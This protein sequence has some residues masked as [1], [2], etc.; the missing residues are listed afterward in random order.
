M[1]YLWYNS[2]RLGETLTAELYFTYTTPKLDEIEAKDGILR[3]WL[4]TTSLTT[5]KL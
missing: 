3:L 4:R 2:S 1:L 5:P